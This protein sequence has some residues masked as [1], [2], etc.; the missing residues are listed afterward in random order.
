MAGLFVGLGYSVEFNRESGLGRFDIKVRDR[1]NR[2]AMILE[3]KKVDSFA[4][5]DAACDE[6]I[7]Q[8]VDKGYAR[9]I[10]PGYEK[11]IS[12]GIAFFQKSVMIKRL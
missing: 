9:T 8:I 11:V 10:E 6:A 1:R 4:R 2:R 3:V 7:K 5:M 12:Y